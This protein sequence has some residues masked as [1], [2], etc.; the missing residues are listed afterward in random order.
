MW[1]QEREETHKKQ[2]ENSPGSGYTD[3]EMER[4]FETEL[5][6][7]NKSDGDKY[8]KL[9]MQNGFD[10]MEIIADMNE[11]DL[12]EMGITKRGHRKYILQKVIQLQ[13]H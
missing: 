6:F 13:L 8:L 4:W 9:F 1:I 3:T 7:Y 11:E 10:S 12:V 2:T 5:N